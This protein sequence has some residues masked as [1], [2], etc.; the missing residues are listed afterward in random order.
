VTPEQFLELLSEDAFL[1][2]AEV[3]GHRYGTLAGTV[4]DL[5]RS[6]LDVVL[7]IDVQGARVVR[8][9]VPDAVL[10]FLR[11]PSLEELA[12]RLRQ[13][14]TEDEG[15]LAKRLD[16]AQEELAQASWFDEVVENDDLSTAVDEVAAI[17]ERHRRT[18]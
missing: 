4:E 6:G 9:R 17:I 13:R 14:G 2:H 8:E 16:E 5:R 10:I 1:E 12:R 7:E 11:P 18:A 15:E 3:F